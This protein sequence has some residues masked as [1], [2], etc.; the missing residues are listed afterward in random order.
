MTSPLLPHRPL[1]LLHLIFHFFL[2]FLFV[3]SPFSP[4]L[5]LSPTPPPLP[6]QSSLESIHSSV[7]VLYWLCVDSLSHAELKGTLLQFLPLA[8]QVS[9]E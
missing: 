7:R 1:L 4:I 2:P 6:L 9:K 3:L 5:S 8:T